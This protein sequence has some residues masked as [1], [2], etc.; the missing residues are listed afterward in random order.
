M[1]DIAP[2][3]KAPNLM[4]GNMGFQMRMVVKAFTLCLQ[5]LYD[6]VSALE[7]PQSTG[8]TGDQSIFAIPGNALAINLPNSTIYPMSGNVT[9]PASAR[10]EVMYVNCTVTG[11]LKIPTFLPSGYLRI[12]NVGSATINLETQ[13]SNSLGSVASGSMIIIYL[14]LDGSGNPKF[15]TPVTSILVS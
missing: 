10:F 12:H 8:S 7:G 4:T 1:N 2:P 5:E 15:V 3:G 9:M 11:T 14:V 6:R 13:N